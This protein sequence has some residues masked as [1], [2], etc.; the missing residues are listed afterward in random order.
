MKSRFLP[1]AAF[2]LSLAAGKLLI[3]SVA[4]P[5]RDTA[6]NHPVVLR[7]GKL[8]QASGRDSALLEKPAAPSFILES[9]AWERKM[10]QLDIADFPATFEEEIRTT[11]ESGR[12]FRLMQIWQERDLQ[13]FSAWCRNQPDSRALPRAGEY[14]EI[15]SGVI[16][17]ACAKSPEFAWKLAK[18]IAPNSVWADRYRGAVIGFLL[19]SDQEAARDFVRQ[20]RDEIQAFRGN[21]GWDGVEPQKALPVALEIP[22]GPVR[23]SIIRELARYYGENADKIGEAKSWFQSLPTENQEDLRRMINVEKLFDTLFGGSPH[24]KEAW[25]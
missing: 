13:N 3:S 1:G 8:D 14:I 11:V 2:I 12:V 17:A 19:G 24:L 20:H 15:F 21:V 25:K 16:S 23:N 10:R 6:Q 5:E 9:I 7:A 22:S 4:V 18:D